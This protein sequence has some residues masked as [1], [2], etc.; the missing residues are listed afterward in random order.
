MG[1]RFD[2]DRADVLVA[3]G[4]EDSLAAGCAARKVRK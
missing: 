3:V 4:L 1:R 2:R